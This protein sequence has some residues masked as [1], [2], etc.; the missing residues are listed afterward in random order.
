MAFQFSNENFSKTNVLKKSFIYIYSKSSNCMSA[1]HSPKKSSRSVT[2]GS[3]DLANQ[4]LKGERSISSIE[5]F[6][7][8]ICLQGLQAS[9]HRSMIENNKRRMQK[10]DSL[11]L[12]LNNL[13]NSSKESM[14]VKSSSSGSINLNSTSSVSA[15]QNYQIDINDDEMNDI[16]SKIQSLLEGCEIDFIDPASIPKFEMVLKMRKA[17]AIEDSD[18]QSAKILEK[19]IQSLSKFK[20]KVKASSPI[21]QKEFIA[22]KEARLQVLYDQLKILTEN[23]AEERNRINTDR[24]E[25]LN[26][27]FAQN[28]KEVDELVEEKSSIMMGLGFKPSK[29]L[30]E[31][32]QQETNLAKMSLF[33]EAS[34]LKKRNDDLEMQE[35]REFDRKSLKNYENKEKDQMKRQDARIQASHEFWKKLLERAESR[36]LP[37]IKMIQNEIDSIIAKIEEITGKKYEQKS[38]FE[39]T[40]DLSGLSFTDNG[41]SNFHLN[42]NDITNSDNHDFDDIVYN[43]NTNSN[44]D[45]NE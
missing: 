23:L 39:S 14:S 36:F 13:M 6:E 15:F 4:I 26:T 34:D 31:L 35:R 3:L 40:L 43:D 10:C 20:K 5:P 18:Y 8:S 16:N 32:R 44:D 21:K 22:E 11:I 30:K 33:D 19:N 24:E 45:D 28:E 12:E 9:R 42:D 27:L 25:S 41:Q 37:K 2:S 7:Y 38:D 1:K 29:R 17:K